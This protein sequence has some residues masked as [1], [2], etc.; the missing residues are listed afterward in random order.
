MK[1]ILGMGSALVDVLI[2]LHDEKPL[3][4]LMLPKGSMQL[5]DSVR[6]DA[7]LGFFK[8]YKKNLAAGGSAAN[9]LHGIGMLG[10]K[11][12]FIGRIGEDEL[13]GSFVKDMTDAGVELHLSKSTTGTGS[14]ITLITPDSER[15][16]A[17]CL[18]AASELSAGHLQS[19]VFNGYDLFHIEGYMVFNQELTGQV[20]KQAKASGLMV[21][22][23]LASY[24]VVEAARDFLHRLIRDEIDIVFANEDEA[25]AF[26]GKEPEA[27]LEEIS[28][29]AS[30]AIVKTGPKGSMIRHNG[31]TFRIGAIPVHPVDTTGAGDLYASGFLYGLA[32]GMPM[33]RCGELGALL[34]G[35]V[36]E[37]IGP[38]MGNEIW[39]GIKKVIR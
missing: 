24:N 5:V 20:V 13:G 31:E 7:V 2:R 30:Y 35:K 15:T 3:D 11:A 14:A 29:M 38:K 19:G 32:N 36:I 9:T 1:R 27:A 33:Q 34:A 37:V 26:T 17:T 39:E 25:R 22:I 16:F 10:G 21:S 28:G 8:E 18:G 4:T 6:R 12:G 23:D